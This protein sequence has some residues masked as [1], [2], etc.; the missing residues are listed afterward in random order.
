MIGSADLAP[1]ILIIVFAAII[2]MWRDD[3]EG[4]GIIATS[5]YDDLQ[6]CSDGRRI[7]VAE[8]CDPVTCWD[9]VTKVANAALCPPKPI[10]VSPP[11]VIVPPAVQ[12]NCATVDDINRLIKA[13]DN[14]GPAKP[15]P[16]TKPPGWKE[17][18]ITKMKTVKEDLFTECPDGSFVKRGGVCGKDKRLSNEGWFSLK[19]GPVD[20]QVWLDEQSTRLRARFPPG[21]PFKFLIEDNVP[22]QAVFTNAKTVDAY[23]IKITGP[24]AKK[25]VRGKRP[26][27]AITTLIYAVTLAVGRV[28]PDELVDAMGK[29]IDIKKETLGIYTDANFKRS[30]TGLRLTASGA[31][32]KRVS[33]APNWVY[34]RVGTASGAAKASPYFR[35]RRVAGAAVKEGLLPLKM[36]QYQES[37]KWWVPQLG[38]TPYIPMNRRITILELK[39]QWQNAQELKVLKGEITKGARLPDALISGRFVPQKTIKGTG[40]GQYQ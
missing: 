17:P 36:Q 9:G 28:A 4:F 39:P 2:V 12:S 14:C 26:E 13:L 21:T 25:I 24:A 23:N 16:P 22:G 35:M 8:S 20:D 7:G 11:A 30:K 3:R 5:S 31:A 1:I 33:T 27:F 29:P 19:F 6:T 10:V 32:F 37:R 18:D 15:P 34:F 38:P 40:A